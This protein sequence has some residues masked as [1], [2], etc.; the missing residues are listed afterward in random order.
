MLLLLSLLLLFSASPSSAAAPF[1]HFHMKCF[2]SVAAAPVFSS[3][4]TTTCRCHPLC[5]PSAENA[6]WGATRICVCVGVGGS[7]SR[8]DAG[9]LTCLPQ[10]WW[11]HPPGECT[12]GLMGCTQTRPPFT[13][14]CTSCNI[15][16]SP[17]FWKDSCSKG[18][19]YRR[20]M[21]ARS[22]SHN[23]VQG[24]DRQSQAFAT[25]SNTYSL[26]SEGC[27]LSCMLLS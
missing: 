4:T 22:L 1:I 17:L 8:V 19:G 3:S 12:S 21:G 2:R 14:G 18:F 10:H 6:R 25:P 26:A 20:G 11:Q 23:L 13:L 15:Q 24:I 27:P 16:H 9:A 5:P 7:K